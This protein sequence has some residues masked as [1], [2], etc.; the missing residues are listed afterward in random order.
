V[1]YDPVNKNVRSDMFYQPKRVENWDDQWDK[2]LSAVGLFWSGIPILIWIN[3]VWFYLLDWSRFFNDEVRKDY[4]PQMYDN[5]FTR[6]FMGD[7]K[8]IYG[9]FKW[10][11][12][13]SV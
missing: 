3:N 1:R 2:W 13:F 5:W 11:D 7:P 12:L 4:R 6:I 8:K 9:A 10:Y